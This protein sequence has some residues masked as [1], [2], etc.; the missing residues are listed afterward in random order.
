MTKVTIEVGNEK[1]VELVRR[2]LEQTR[3]RRC[4]DRQ[5]VKLAPQTKAL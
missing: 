1:R 5:L 2:G 3:V 4:F